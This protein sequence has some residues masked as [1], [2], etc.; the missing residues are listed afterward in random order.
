VVNPYKSPEQSQEDVVVARLWPVYHQMFASIFT[1]FA[2]GFAIFWA[3]RL[4]GHEAPLTAVEIRVWLVLVFGTLL[5]CFA[6]SWLRTNYL[7]VA[8]VFRYAFGIAGTPSLASISVEMF[9]AWYSGVEF[10]LFAFTNRAFGDYAW[11]YWIDII[12]TSVVPIVICVHGVTRRRWVIVPA[13]VFVC[14][15]AAADLR[16]SYILNHANYLPSSWSHL[17]WIP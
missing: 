2:A 10:E 11:V 5:V 3:W 6:S 14:L 7:N 17:F 12:A 13:L 16:F 8:S 9:M 4:L 1:I 15:V